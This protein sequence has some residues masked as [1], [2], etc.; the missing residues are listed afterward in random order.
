MAMHTDDKFWDLEKLV[1]VNWLRSVQWRDFCFAFLN[2]LWELDELG[3]KSCT[4]KKM[5]GPN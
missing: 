3:R 2:V 1:S 5:G 4:E